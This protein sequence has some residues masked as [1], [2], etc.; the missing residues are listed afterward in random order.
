MRPHLRPKSKYAEWEDP[1]QEGEPFDY[2]AEPGRFYFEL[3]SVG[4]LDPDG[5]VHEG[6]KALQKKLAELIQGL[7][8]G[9]GGADVNGADDAGVGG[10][11]PM[12]MDGG[13][14]GWREQGFT[15]PY[16]NGGNQSS[17]G[18]GATPYGT[19]PYGNPG[20]SGWS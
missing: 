10:P 18:G 8:E 14:G 7:N 9:E 16:A 19:T 11:D 2:D 5:I 20:Q 6:I 3:E 13:D 12:S 1:P 4:G 17:W 15:T